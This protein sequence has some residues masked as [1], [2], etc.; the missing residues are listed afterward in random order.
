MVRARCETADVRQVAW[1]AW[2]DDRRVGVSTKERLEAVADA[3]DAEVRRAVAA[4][5]REIQGSLEGLANEYADAAE[6]WADLDDDE[7]W[8]ESENLGWA[9]GYDSSVNHLRLFIRKLV[10]TAESDG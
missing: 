8:P 2:G 6:E 10:E 3:V 1:K 7:E 9:K 4:G 5:L